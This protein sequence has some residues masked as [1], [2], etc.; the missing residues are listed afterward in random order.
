MI[1]ELTPIEETVAGRELIEI[2]MERGMERGMGQL[3]IDMISEKFGQ[4]SVEAR[5]GVEALPMKDLPDLGRVLFHFPD[6][7]ALE[8]WLRIRPAT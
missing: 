5:Q 8:S 7:A 3:L 1:D 2:G 4:V 6:A